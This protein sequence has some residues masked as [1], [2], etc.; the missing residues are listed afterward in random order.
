VA[1]PRPAVSFVSRLIRSRG[2]VDFSPD[3]MEFLYY[4]RV[5]DTTRLKKQFGYQPVFSTAQ[6]FDSFLA[7]AGIAPVITRDAV[8]RVEATITEGSRSLVGAAE[9]VTR[10]HGGRETVDA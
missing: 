4:G 2:L 10:R 3:Q 5:V 6:A 9:A 7:G 1:V 8:G